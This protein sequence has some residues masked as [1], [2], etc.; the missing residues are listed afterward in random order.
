MNP[1]LRNLIS[2]SKV[3][4]QDESEGKGWQHNVIETRSE[5]KTSE[6]ICKSVQQK[7]DFS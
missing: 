2:E 3:G 5:T 1:W 4:N 7:Y 6:L